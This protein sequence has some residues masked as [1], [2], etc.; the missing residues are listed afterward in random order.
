MERQYRTCTLQGMLVYPLSID[1]SLN[2]F[3]GKDQYMI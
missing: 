3:L 1:A 2:L